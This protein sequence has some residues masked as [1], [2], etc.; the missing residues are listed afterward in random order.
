M[1]LVLAVVVVIVLQNEIGV[2][3]EM[4]TET[5]V[6]I[7]IEAETGIEN[8]DA[9]ETMIEGAALEVVGGI[10]K[11]EAA[12]V[13]A[14]VGRTLDERGIQGETEVVTE[15]AT[16]AEIASGTDEGGRAR[17]GRTMTMV[18]REKEAKVTKVRGP[19]RETKDITRSYASSV[20]AHSGTLLKTFLFASYF[21]ISIPN[22]IAPDNDITFYVP[23][24]LH[25]VLKLYDSRNDKV[26]PNIPCTVEVRIDKCRT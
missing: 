22:A 10:E 1:Y 19:L 26:L 20:Y 8:G 25:S 3:G 5:V 15:V 24:H 13:V 21:R 18:E 23:I 2:A 9:R 14:A 16:G 12:A 6:V 17:I 7:E 4:M 11:I